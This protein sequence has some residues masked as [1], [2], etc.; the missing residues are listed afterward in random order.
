MLSTFVTHSFQEVASIFGVIAAIL[1][2]GNL[3]FQDKTS[4][5]NTG[6][7]V[8]VANTE[9]TQIG[10]VTLCNHSIIYKH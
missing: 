1:H 9:L 5:Q 3:E 6:D 7:G 10:T 2:T 4:D 8:E